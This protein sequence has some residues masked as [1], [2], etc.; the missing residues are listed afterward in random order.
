MSS[1]RRLERFLLLLVSSGHFSPQPNSLCISCS[2]LQYSKAGATSCS[3]CP[4]GTS[5]ISSTTECQTCP[6]GTFGTV[7]VTCTVCT[8]NVI[9]PGP[10]ATSCV[11]CT[12]GTFASGGITDGSGNVLIGNK[13]CVPCPAGTYDAGAG[14]CVACLGNQI[15]TGGSTGCTPCPPDTIPDA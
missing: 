12:P 2:Q 3:L 15:S 8:N 11:P 5:F 13:H 1:G 7:Q 14:T 9:S 6:A 10:G 4:L